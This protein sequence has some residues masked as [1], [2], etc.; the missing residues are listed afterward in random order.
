[1]NGREATVIGINI[2]SMDM[3]NNPAGVKVPIMVSLVSSSNVS[4][5]LYRRNGTQ[6]SKDSVLEVMRDSEHME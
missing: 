2:R 1:M 3:T 5:T 6:Q 4:I